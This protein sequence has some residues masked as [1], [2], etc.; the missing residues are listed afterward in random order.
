MAAIVGRKAA[1]VEKK[2]GA[3]PPPQPPGPARILTEQERKAREIG[4]PAAKEA[5][6]AV[7]RGL[8]NLDKRGPEKKR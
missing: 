4:A 1:K 8:S 3:A 5:I 7:E 6:A 2:T